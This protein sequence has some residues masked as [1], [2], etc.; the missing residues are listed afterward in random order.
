MYLEIVF[1]V[2]VEFV[3]VE[4]VEEAFGSSKIPL[5]DVALGEVVVGVGEGGGCG[6]GGG[7]FFE[8]KD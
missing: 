1:F 7:D 5:D 6:E 4:D 2:E 8:H 3:G